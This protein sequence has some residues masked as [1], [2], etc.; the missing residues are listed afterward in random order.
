MMVLGKLPYLREGFDDGRYLGNGV[1]EL[2]L[3]LVELQIAAAH[4]TRDVLNVVP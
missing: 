4:C 3:S 2:E 1:E